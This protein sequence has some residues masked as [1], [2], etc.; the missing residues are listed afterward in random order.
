MVT[1]VVELFN[2]KAFTDGLESFAAFATE[3]PL[4]LVTDFLIVL[5]TLTPAV[6]LRRRVFYTS[7]VAIL[8]LIGGAAQRVYP[9][10]PDDALYHGGPDRPQQRIGY[11]AQLPLDGVYRAVGGCGGCDGSGIGPA[12]L[13]GPPKPG[14]Q[15]EAPLR[16]HSGH[17]DESG[18]FVLRL[19]GGLPDPISSP[20]CFPTWQRRMR[21]TG[22]PIAFCR[23]GSTKESH[24]PWDTV[25]AV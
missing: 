6:F 5:A 14:S 13:E 8:W 22:F 24:S 11:P 1:L 23:P 16:R 15:P 19:G 12:V 10:Q 18:R 3:H 17:A 20:R 9:A 7:L 21:T 2:H 4:A 25:P